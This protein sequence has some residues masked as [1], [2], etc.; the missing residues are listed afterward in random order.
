MMKEFAGSE[1]RK[2]L[3]AYAVDPDRRMQLAKIIF[4]QFNIPTGESMDYIVGRR[5]PRQANGEV[6]FALCF[7]ADQMDGGSRV[8]T[9]F[10]KKEIEMLSSMRRKDN[11]VSFPIEIGCFQVR[12][13]TQWIGITHTDF[14][15]QLFE[16]QIIN[17]N[18]EAQ[19]AMKMHVFEG[20]AFYRVSINRKAVDAICELMLNRQYVPNT[21]TLNL[22]ERVEYYYNQ[23][24][25]R[26]VISKADKLDILDGYH[27]LLA[28]SRA[29]AIDPSFDYPME[30][31]IMNLD[32]NA[33][34]HFIYQEDQK[35]KMRKIDSDSMSNAPWNTVVDR[36]V[37]RYPFQGVIGRN[38]GVINFAEIASVIKYYYFQERKSAIE[39]N[40]MIPVVVNEICERGILAIE[41]LPEIVGGNKMSYMRIMALI[42]CIKEYDGDELVKH[43]KTYLK[44]E[45]QM[46]VRLFKQKTARKGLETYI[47]KYI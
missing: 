22:S 26:L 6:I 40:R 25:N 7:G 29:K 39:T 33:A 36:L 28:M 43:L 18:P 35:T 9:Y 11:G 47:K 14:L 23:K 30:L 46:D 15:I 41:A 45:A 21:I 17:Y 27:R 44:N 38:G 42:H 8:E 12:E 31:R 16:A 13:G 10:N 37:M 24:L 32:D 4:D 20:N 2:E 5:D 19:R 34:R 3:T 1:L